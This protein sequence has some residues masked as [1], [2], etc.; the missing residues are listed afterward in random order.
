[1]EEV[2]DVARDLPF[3][4]VRDE[5][6]NQDMALVGHL[7]SPSRQSG[8]Q[9]QSISPPSRTSESFEARRRLQVCALHAK[10]KMLQA[11]LE[12]RQFQASFMGSSSR[13]QAICPSEQDLDPA[14]PIPRTQ[15]ST[16]TGQARRLASVQEPSLRH[17][18]MH[19][20]AE[21]QYSRKDTEFIHAGLM[22]RIENLFRL[23]P[24]SSIS[25]GT[26]RLESVIRLT[27][28][29]P[30][31]RVGR[32]AWEIFNGTRT[33][34]FPSAQTNTSTTALSTSNFMKPATE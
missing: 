8:E 20:I 1:M 29:A 15:E 10:V 23:V 17:T 13:S 18:A 26:L 14:S 21:R 3:L 16:S 28:A 27:L 4:I 22:G 19:A 9:S 24:L 7:H 6:L 32:A 11:K 34:A 31:D 33:P 5:E 2:W 30:C 25:H 12:E